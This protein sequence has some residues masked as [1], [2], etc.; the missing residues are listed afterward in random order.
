MQFITIEWP[1]YI[2]RRMDIETLPGLLF[3]DLGL[4][5]IPATITATVRNLAKR[6]VAFV[7]V[8]PTCV[9]AALAGQIGG[10]PRIVISRV[11]S[12]GE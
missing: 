12:E 11:I 2:E 1:E 7:S 3:L 9:A 6:N 5:D 4:Y 10:L 8:H